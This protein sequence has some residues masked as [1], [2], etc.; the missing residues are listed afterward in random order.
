MKEYGLFQVETTCG[1]TL[2]SKW[3][4][5]R[6]GVGVVGLWQG[7]KKVIGKACHSGDLKL[8]YTNPN[9]IST[10]PQNILMSRIHFTVLL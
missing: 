9:V 10:S 2:E 3:G 7:A 8:A 5:G 6:W 1:H 4:G